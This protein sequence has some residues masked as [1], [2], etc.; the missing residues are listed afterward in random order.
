MI[1]AVAGHACWYTWGVYEPRR[2]SPRWRARPEAGP[3]GSPW[4]SRALQRLLALSG[5]AKISSGPQ[6]RDAAWPS[7]RRGRLPVAPGRGL[8]DP[9]D[10]ELAEHL[11]RVSRGDGR[12][13]GGVAGERVAV[14][15]TR[16]QRR[17]PRPGAPG[18]PRRGAQIDGA[19]RHLD[20]AAVLQRD[21]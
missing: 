16:R 13:P 7:P 12:L 9:H 20:A 8:V 17:E 21:A 14:A 1:L 6:R 3:P 4:P 2:R 11:D 5:W 18:A 15:A 10:V 19:G